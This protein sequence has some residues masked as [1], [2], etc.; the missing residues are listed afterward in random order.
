MDD[1]I[2]LYCAM[3][4]TTTT[5]FYLWRGGASYVGEMYWS[6][7]AEEEPVQTSRLADQTQPNPEYIKCRFMATNGKAMRNCA[8]EWK[9]I[10]KYNYDECIFSV[11]SN[12]TARRCVHHII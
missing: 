5:G 4:S 8:T 3:N 2:V 11:L 1:T 9:R 7:P 12:R 10:R 6:H